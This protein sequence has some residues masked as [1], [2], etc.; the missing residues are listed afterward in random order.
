[1]KHT[2]LA[3]LALTLA[4]AGLRAEE[5]KSSYSL[6]TDFFFVSEYIFRGIEQQDAAFQPAVTFTKDTLSLGVWTSQALTN[7]SLVWAQG[8]EIDLWGT[9][10]FKLTDALTATVGGTAYLYPSARPSLS[11][12][13]ETYELSLGVSAPLGPLTGSATYFKDFVLESNTFQFGVAY[14]IPLPEGKGSFDLAA[15]YAFNDIGD[16]DGDLPGTAG[17]DYRYYALSGTFA[18]KLTAAATLKLGATYTG[19]NRIPGAPK[20]LVFTV[21]VSAGL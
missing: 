21:G 17:Y 10:G 7:K 15:T 18:Y 1:M 4:S 14:S 9:Y 19:V 8:S 5:P 20:N 13:D 2:L 11:E 16:G 6:T 3:A 12:P